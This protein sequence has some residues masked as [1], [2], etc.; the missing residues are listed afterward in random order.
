MSRLA[1]DVVGSGLDLSQG[2]EI[3]RDGGEEGLLRPGLL[4]PR[5][6][7]LHDARRRRHAARRRRQRRRGQ[8]QAH[9]GRD[10]ADQGRPARPR[11]CGR[12]ARA[13]HR[14]PRHQPRPAQHRPVA[15]CRRSQAASNARDGRRR[16]AGGA[17]HARPQGARPPMRRSRRCAGSSS[18]SCRSRRRYAPLYESIKRS[19]VLLFGALFLA[20]LAGMFLARR[21]VVPIQ[22]LREGAE[23]IG[24]RRAQPAHRV[25]TG[26]E[27]EA[28]ADQFN[29]MA[30]QLAGVLRRSR[31]EGRGPHERADRVAAAADRDRRRAARSSAARPSTCSRCLIRSS[32]LRRGCAR[33]TRHSFCLRQGELFHRRRKPRLFAGVRGVDQQNPISSGRGTITGR[34]EAEGRTIHIHDVLADPE[35]A[36]L[37]SQVRGGYRTALGVPLLRGGAPIGVSVLTRPVVGHSPRSRSSSSPPS[38]TRR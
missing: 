3:R 5:V 14:P 7:A 30:G 12:T 16:A 21:M 28:L 4:P 15:A 29:D 6:R 19:G 18:S 27:L 31:A 32:I 1:M 37:E 20:A 36:R 38:P 22:A 13:A 8:P 34:A 2:P 23:R 35:Y 26:D 25:K 11:L 33:P 10:L 9:L 24:A 17:R